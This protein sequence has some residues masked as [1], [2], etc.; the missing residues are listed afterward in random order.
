MSLVVFISLFEARPFQTA[1]V[2]IFGARVLVCM[3]WCR[4]TDKGALDSHFLE[5]GNEFFIFIFN[6][7]G[8]M[9]EELQRLSW[10]VTW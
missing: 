1:I 10:R 9:I 7:L 5:R 6:S 3:Y 4:H 2:L 8:A